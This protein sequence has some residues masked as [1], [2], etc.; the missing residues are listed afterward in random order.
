MSIPGLVVGVIA[1]GDTIYEGTFGDAAPGGPPVSVDTPFTLGSTSK[2]FA[3]LA[4][5]QL[6]ADGR[7]TLDQTV[8]ELLPLLIPAGGSVY[9]DVTVAQ[10]LSHRSGFSLNSGLAEWR[11]WLDADTLPEHARMLLGETPIAE[12]GAV[13]Q[14]SNANYT[15]LGAI[16]EEVTGLSYPSALDALVIDPLGLTSTTGVLAVAQNDGLAAWNYPWYGILNVV[17]PQPAYEAAVPSAFVCSTATDLE[18]L[19]KAHLGVV[20]T[21]M[22]GATLAEAREPIAAQNEYSEYASGWSIRPFWE[23][24]D[25]DEDWDDGTLPEIWEHYGTTQRSF[26]YL[27]MQPEMGLGIVLLANTGVALDQNRVYGLV[28]GLLHEVANTQALPIEVD[29]LIAIAPALIIAVPLLVAGAIVW[30]AITLRHHPRSRIA[31]W[32]PVAFGGVVVIGSLYLTLVVVPA[33]TGGALYDTWWWTGVP[34][35]AVSTALMLLLSIVATTL[36]VAVTLGHS[37]PTSP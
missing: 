11:L 31:R 13:Y 12:P 16:I 21:G 28:Y 5:Q 7:L 6:V 17:T 24:R 9:D 25:L 14:Y 37:R 1:D 36:I 19:L 34:D 22:S 8:A 4:I 3:G 20:Q 15:L 29:P 23:L 2:Q 30:L 35:L 33:R 18:R 27:G 32:A 10:L 26:T